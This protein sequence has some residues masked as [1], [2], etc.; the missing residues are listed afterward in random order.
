MLAFLKK[1]F[2]KKED[3]D[4]FVLMNNDILYNDFIVKENVQNGKYIKSNNMTISSSK[5]ESAITNDLPLKPNNV[6]NDIPSKPNLDPQ[7]QN[8]ETNFEGFKKQSQ[9][10]DL[11]QPADMNMIDIHERLKDIPTNEFETTIV[12]P[13]KASID[14][15]NKAPQNNKSYY[16]SNEFINN[17]NINSQDKKPSIEEGIYKTSSVIGNSNNQVQ[18]TNDFQDYRQNV[19]NY[20]NEWQ[21]Y[22]KR[23]L[24]SNNEN[25]ISSVNIVPI[26]VQA[27]EKYDTESD[28]R[29]NPE[30]E[31]TQNL[32]ILQFY[33][34]LNHF[35]E[36]SEEEKIY[37][38]VEKAKN[39]LHYFVKVINN[40]SNI[41]AN[42]SV[43]AKLRDDMREENLWVN[44]VKYNNFVFEGFLGN[45]PKVIKNVKYGD[46]LKVNIDDVIDWMF[47]ENERL[48]GGYSIRVARSLMNEQER[49]KFDKSLFFFIDEGVDH[50]REDLSTPEGAIT[51]YEEAYRRKDLNIIL[52]CKNFKEEA[53]IYM[54]KKFGSF[55]YDEKSLVDLQESL[56]LSFIKK[57]E[58][59]GF[60]EI[61]WRKR[62]FTR[63]DYID[64]DLVLVTEWVFRD[65]GTKDRLR[66]YVWRNPNYMWKILCE[67]K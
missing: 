54:L 12:V 51:T 46:I 29:I 15:I 42:F 17:E 20:N 53:K 65:D 2:G 27:K 5:Q 64:E 33:K 16:T 63:R 35:K 14:N 59:E 8:L 6:Y 24:K 67:E 62:A 10:N 25:D 1:I 44:D 38:S 7:L 56:K 55:F 18:W 48:I 31:N 3:P 19:N 34:D 66:Y 57:I 13:R 45:F 58:I 41:H 61:N 9:S 32:S 22:R 43:K 11:Y 40:P 52:K 50:F 30:L 60:K 4:D 49:E 21:D 47:I 28:Y 39:T 37:L 23:D 36:L 26:N